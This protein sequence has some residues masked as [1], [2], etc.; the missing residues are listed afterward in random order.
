MSPL[1]VAFCTA[2]S[3]TLSVEWYYLKNNYLTSRSKVKVP[4][5]SWRYATRR[6]MV[7][8]PNIIDLSRKTKMLWPGQENTISGWRLWMP[9]KYLYIEFTK[10]PSIP[11]IRTTYLFNLKP[12]LSILSMYLSNHLICELP[13]SNI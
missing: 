9:S 6:L 5:R 3:Y 7:M 12:S 1:N 10:P 11:C 2:I 13:M 8:H 4:R